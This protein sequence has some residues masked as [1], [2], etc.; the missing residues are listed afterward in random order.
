MNHWIT[1][2]VSLPKLLRALT[3]DNARALRLDHDIGTVE[4]GKTANLLRLAAN[5]LQ[6]VE[7]YDRIETVFLHGRPLPRASFSARNAPLNSPICRSRGCQVADRVGVWGFGGL[8]A[9][10]VIQSRLGGRRNDCMLHGLT[11]SAPHFSS[12][13]CF[14]S[15]VKRVT[16]AGARS[17]R[18]RS[19]AGPNG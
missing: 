18:E 19:G 4:P 5:P 9:R 14:D 13:V 16:A 15:I 8:P 3:I 12:V 1:A 10:A 2:G 11:P 7:A 17:D 6:T